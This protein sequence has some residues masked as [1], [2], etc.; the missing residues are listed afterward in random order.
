M[1]VDIFVY[2]CTLKHLLHAPF[3]RR[4]VALIIALTVCAELATAQKN[5]AIHGT[6]ENGAGHKIELWTVSDPISGYEE[7]IDSMR[8]GE[9]GRFELRCYANYPMMV[10]LQVENYAQSFYVDAAREYSVYIPR[11]DWNLD[12]KRNV[13]L[14]PEPLPVVFR[15]LPPD[16]IN[17]A[18]DSIDRV[19]ARFID[20]NYF[21]FDMKFKP[22]VRYFDSLTVL[23][24]KLFPDGEQEF[25]NRYKRYQLAELCYTLRFDSRKNMV[26]R[27]VRNQPILY[28]DENYM[29]L[30]V[31]LYG[32]TIS[33]GTRDISVYRLSHWVQNL[34]LK[35]YID[36]I[37]MDPLLRHEQVRELAALLA[38][39]ESYYNFRYYDAEMVVKMIEKLAE[40]SKFPDHKRIA[41]NILATLH[42]SDADAQP[43]LSDF[44]LPDVD[45]QP[46]SLA[47]LR[48]KWVYLAFVQVND[49]TSQSEIETMAHFKEQVYKESDSVAFVTIACDREFQKM[50]HFLKNTRHGGRYQWTWLHFD[51]NY[52]LLRHFQIVSYPWFVLVAPDGS[53]PYSITPAPSTGFLMR[54]PWRRQVEV[55]DAGT[56]QKFR[57]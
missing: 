45:K 31:L 28:H 50:F 13:F 12:E 39:K 42:Q 52:D 43:A 9:D 23:L 35:T 49:P 16:D 33:K 18:I 8:I 37:G 7:L 2:F 25:V 51:G 56:Q 5:I 34:D 3:M 32:N 10:T 53:L 6:S 29:S 48:G 55:E 24:D 21:Y 4:F 22:S 36:S 46:V 1:R 54:G 44:V 26:N 15:N 11:F 19:I 40:R 20:E 27:Y 17:I 47:S 57:Y 41:R 38:L 30:F 14:A